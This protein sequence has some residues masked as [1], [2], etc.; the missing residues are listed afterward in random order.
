MTSDKELRV[1]VVVAVVFLVIGILCFAAFSKKAPEKPVRIMYKSVAG[2]VLFDHKTH[3][4]ESGYGLSC[5]DCHHHYEEDETGKFSCGKC[6]LRSDKD[7]TGSE[8]CADCHEPDEV[9]TEGV[10]KITD[11]LH[12][13]CTGCHLEN[14]AGPEK[15]ECDKCHA[16]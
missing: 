3:F 1:A 10:M 11:A 12:S 9:E 4:S 14:Q 8:V 2:N 5:S 13:Q 7:K 15:E 6:H 16:K